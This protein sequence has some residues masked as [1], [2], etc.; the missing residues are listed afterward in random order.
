MENE[1]AITWKDLNVDNFLKHWKL[2][3]KIPVLFESMIFNDK[4]DGKQWRYPTYQEFEK[5]EKLLVGC[6]G[7]GCG[8]LLLLMFSIIGFILLYAI[9]K[10]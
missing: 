10:T 4:L 8:S 6:S 7:L 5:E 2:V 3:N 1:H 9:F